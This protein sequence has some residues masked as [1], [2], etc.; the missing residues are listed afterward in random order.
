MSTTDPRATQKS[1]AA[2]SGPVS[3]SDRK[4]AQ[5]ASEP[6]QSESLSSSAPSVNVALFLEARKFELGRF[7]SLA[8][9]R[10]HRG[11]DDDAEGAHMPR[12]G[13]RVY[14]RRL[15][16]NPAT[17][18]TRAALHVNLAWRR[19]KLA[20]AVN[21]HRQHR[22]RLA[23]ARRASRRS[24]AFRKV[25]LLRTARPRPGA[26]QRQQQGT[27]TTAKTGIRLRL[28]QPIASYAASRFLHADVVLC[29]DQAGA[30][31]SASLRGRIA[32]RSLHGKRLHASI[33]ASTE[34]CTVCDLSFAVDVLEIFRSEA[35]LR[36]ALGAVRMRTPTAGSAIADRS[37]GEVPV[38]VAGAGPGREI[39]LVPRG[40]REGAETE[41]TFASTL[42]ARI[43][44]RIFDHTPNDDLGSNAAP[45]GVQACVA[46]NDAVAVLEFCGPHALDV[47]NGAAAG[48]AKTATR[49]S[50]AHVISLGA[51]GEDSSSTALV[52]VVPSCPGRLE[53]QWPAVY[54]HARSV[55][56]A[57]IVVSG[58]LPIGV[59]E[60]E[61]VRRQLLWPWRPLLTPLTSE[62]AE[63]PCHGD[64][65]VFDATTAKAA[66]GVEALTATPR[67]PRRARVQWL[68]M[69]NGKLLPAWYC[70]RYGR[71]VTVVA[72]HSE[73]HAALREAGATALGSVDARGLLPW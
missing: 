14:R 11:L 61:A 37:I 8:L 45:S 2:G 62:P 41:P 18:A 33:R 58:A 3:A 10:R 42:Q 72:A 54:R 38:L 15:S 70:W 63:Y 39:I 49:E 71:V 21:R 66:L 40:R 46:R 9:A 51:E 5:P 22:R 34:H 31:A 43:T 29:G 36:P 1:S 16:T 35:I 65:V 57:A 44:A 23:A 68:Q 24:I 17:A 56:H 59:E 69:R 19:R 13:R 64:S 28:L 27:T 67:G 32:V 20:R 25:G 52:L 48:A 50:I 73:G 12:V 4:A 60:R 47:A 26:P 55:L 30:A 6:A 53:E 7:V